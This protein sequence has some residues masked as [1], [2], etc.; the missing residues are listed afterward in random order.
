M[1]NS[2]NLNRFFLPTVADNIR[3]EV[4]K[5]IATVQELFMIMTDTRRSPQAVKRFMNFGAKAFGS[6]WAV[7]GYVEKNVPKVG[8]GFR[9]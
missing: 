4:P 9:R 6:I 7:V 3:V 8:L 5:A 1:H 2:D